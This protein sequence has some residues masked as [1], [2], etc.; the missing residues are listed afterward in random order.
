MKELTARPAKVEKRKPEEWI[1]QVAS[2]QK[3]TGQVGTNKLSSDL[4]YREDVEPTNT[5]KARLSGKLVVHDCKGKNAKKDVTEGI[6]LS[7]GSRAN[8]DVW[9][10]QAN[11]YGKERSELPSLIGKVSEDKMKYLQTQD[12]EPALSPLQDDNRVTSEVNHHHQ[13]VSLEV[14]DISLSGKDQKPTFGQ[15]STTRTRTQVGRSEEPDARK[16]RCAEAVEYSDSQNGQ[17]AERCESVSLGEIVIPDSKQH[18]FSVNILQHSPGLEREKRNSQQWI[19]QNRTHGTTPSKS[20]H[21]PSGKEQAYFT[22][23]EPATA[24]DGSTPG[25]LII[26]D[27]HDSQD[28][29]SSQIQ[30]VIPP[31]IVKQKNNEQWT[32]QII[33]HEGLQSKGPRTIQILDNHKGQSITTSDNVSSATGTVV[34][35]FQHSISIQRQ[36]GKHIG[37]ELIQR[38]TTTKLRAGELQFVNSGEGQQ[39]ITLDGPSDGTIVIPIQIENVS[40]SANVKIRNA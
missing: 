33:T 28:I 29:S 12:M 14:Q 34:P 38:K 30:E 11:K 18:S 9:I 7:H 8:V 37:D 13:N 32:T 5:S 26:L 20:T 3:S 24:L 4:V 1:T 31:P 39:V 23:T 36:D 35:G 25:G 22:Y 21:G 27:V 10:T 2:I 16:R 17:R 40:S 19:T 15:W 6:Q